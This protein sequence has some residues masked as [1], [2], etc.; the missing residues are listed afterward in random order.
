MELLTGALTWAS[1]V[2]TSL[3]LGHGEQTLANGKR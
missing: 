1:A 2:H 3:T